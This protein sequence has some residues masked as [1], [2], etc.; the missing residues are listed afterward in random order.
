MKFHSILRTF[1]F[2]ALISSFATL[3]F[4]VMPPKPGVEAPPNFSELVATIS[5]S[6]Q[7]GGLYEAMQAYKNNSRDAQPIANLPVLLG[8]YSDSQNYYTQEDFDNLLFG[9]NST[10]N[11]IDYYAEISYGQFEVQGTVMDWVTAPNSQ[12]Y[13]AGNDNG[14]GGGGAQFSYDLAVIN[15]PTVDY[16]QFDNDG[17]DG[18]PNS[19]DDDG[20]VDVLVVVHTGGGAEA[21][22]SDNIWSHRWSFQWAGVGA[23]VSDDP[24]ANGGFIRVN[25]YIIQPETSGGGQY[26]ESQV[27]IGVFC[28]EFGH[29]LGLPDLYDTDYSSEGIGNWGLMAG[30]SWGMGG[31]KPVHMCAWSKVQL[32][33]IDPIVI[34]ENTEMAELPFVEQHP[35]VYKLWTNGSETA[36]YFLIENRR[37]VM[38]DT[39]IPGEGLCVWHVDHTAGGNSNEAH[40]LVDLEAADG[41]THMDDNGNSG[42]AG[43]VFP[44]SS[45]NRSFTGLTQPNSRDYYDQETF[46]GVLDISDSDTLMTATLRVQ[47]VIPHFT[48]NTTSGHAPLNIHFTDASQASTGDVS[49]WAWDF[50]SDGTIDSNEQD[51]D[52]E[53]TDPGSYS[54]T[55]EVGNATFTETLV[56]PDM[57]HVFSGESALAFNGQEGSVMFSASPS[58]DVT[59]TLTFEAWIRPLGW[60]ESGAAGFGRV[61]DKSKIAFYTYGSGAALNDHSLALQIG[62]V[63]GGV[64][65]VNTP[66]NSI[67]PGFWQH[68]AVSYDAA[69]STAVI[70]INGVP[71]ELSV[72]G[73]EPAGAVSEHSSMPLY[74]G[75]SASE[76]Q[77]FEG[78]IDEVRFWN[79]IRSEADIYEFM[80]QA[81]PWGEDGLVGYWTLNEGSGQAVA[82]FSGNGNAGIINSA[83]WTEGVYTTL[84]VEDDRP[85]VET[86]PGQVALAQNYPNPFNPATTIAFQLP[87]RKPVKLQVFNASGQLVKT[88]VDGTLD[89]GSHHSTWDGTNDLN[90]AV[91]SGVYFYRLQT[92]TDQATRRM[93]L[94]K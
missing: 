87:D 78:K 12:Y 68:V 3:S 10:G 39:T 27:K 14:L 37:K 64:G 41:F 17:P 66:E 72:V 67:V 86:L 52:F 81:L 49:F 77:T 20:Y 59:E 13:Y 9:E 71:Q 79:V 47:G 75:N 30:G 94:L 1:L 58:L 31:R 16:G 51:P 63:D 46:V 29:G 38:F 73:S 53:F 56:V 76:G 85:S 24:A 7:S 19:G 42:D 88:L 70:Y 33:W 91:T 23:Y 35:V 83:A 60:G 8:R 15:D 40:K 50:D 11:M 84:A 69:S 92:D 6:Y 82:D 43:D 90:G 93:V 22:D 45:D 36:Q 25:D 57:I 28:H 21:G 55:L 89:A 62:T 26:G 34:T 80:A 32:G 48:V 4:A 2:T 5:Q 18:V 65:V 44:G 61:F 74:I 54:V